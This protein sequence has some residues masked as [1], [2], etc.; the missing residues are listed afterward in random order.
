M[1]TYFKYGAIAFVV[2]STLLW[3]GENLYFMHYASQ[4]AKTACAGKTGFFDGPN[5]YYWC[6]RRVEAGGKP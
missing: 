2:I 1:A 4:R 3:A 6:L 5:S